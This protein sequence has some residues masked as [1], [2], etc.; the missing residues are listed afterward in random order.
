MSPA[1]ALRGERSVLLNVSWAKCVELTSLRY[2]GQDHVL[3]AGLRLISETPVQYDHSCHNRCY[4]HTKLSL[5]V[6]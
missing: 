6:A 4:G 5:Q 3:W 2:A 1:D